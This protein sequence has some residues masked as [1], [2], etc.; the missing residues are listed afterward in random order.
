MSR[1]LYT[2]T[3]R[4]EMQNSHT[5]VVELRADRLV[6]ISEISGVFNRAVKMVETM[7]DGALEPVPAAAPGGW[8]PSVVNG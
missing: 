4:V 5:G 3:L 7:R 6:T 8:K 2:V 1:P